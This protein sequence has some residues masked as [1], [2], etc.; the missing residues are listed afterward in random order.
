MDD[1][2]GLGEILNEE[3][4]KVI[5]NH[6]FAFDKSQKRLLQKERDQSIIT[7][8]TTLE[9]DYEFKTLDEKMKLD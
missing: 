2:R 3:G 1:S 4:L 6:L 5:T 9:E 8:Y 7:H